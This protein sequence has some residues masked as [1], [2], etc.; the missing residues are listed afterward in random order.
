M[1]RLHEGHY[2]SPQIRRPQSAN[3]MF[4]DQQKQ[5]SA[6]TGVGDETDGQATYRFDSECLK[7]MDDSLTVIALFITLYLQHANIEML[8]VNSAKSINFSHFS[9]IHIMHYFH[10]H[11][12]MSSMLESIGLSLPRCHLCRIKSTFLEQFGVHALAL[13][14]FKYTF[15]IN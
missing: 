13:I 4:M 9:S 5:G 1:H 8:G 6:Q 15:Y 3:Q 10:S 7:T 14:I 2:C 12:I 11:K